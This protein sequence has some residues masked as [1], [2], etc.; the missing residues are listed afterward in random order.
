MHFSYG[1]G[2]LVGVFR[3]DTIFKR[4]DKLKEEKY[5]EAIAAIL[6]CNP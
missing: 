5:K 3:I 6:K 2:S 4:K 1:F